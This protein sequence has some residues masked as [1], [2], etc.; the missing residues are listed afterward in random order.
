MPLPKKI[1]IELL[2]AEWGIVAAILHSYLENFEE[3]LPQ[4][5]IEAV[6]DIKEAIMRKGIAWEE[7]IP[8][9]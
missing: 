2:P 7:S 1:S 8:K 3:L 4:W 9:R 6:R 5:N